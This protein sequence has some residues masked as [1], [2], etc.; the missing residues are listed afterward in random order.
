MLSTGIASSLCQVALRDL[1][2]A[3]NRLKAFVL[4]RRV[5]LPCLEYLDLSDNSI[6]TVGSINSCVA[7][8]VLLLQ[9]NALTDVKPLVEATVG[10]VMLSVLR[11]DGNRIPDIHL[12]ALREFKPSLIISDPGTQTGQLMAST[13]M[14][15][16]GPGE[17]GGAEV[18]DHA[19][20]VA[21]HLADNPDVADTLDAVAD[22]ADAVASLTERVRGV[23]VQVG[24]VAPVGDPSMI[25]MGTPPTFFEDGRVRAAG[26][27]FRHC[28]YIVWSLRALVCT[29]S[30]SSPPPS[31]NKRLSHS[32]SA[33]S[34]STFSPTFVCGGRWKAVSGGRWLSRCRRWPCS[35]APSRQQQRSAMTFAAPSTR[36]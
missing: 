9:G 3:N 21:D 30:L 25:L 18:P 6:F 33:C 8:N 28:N 1:R 11:L 32:S 15:V 36:V 10:C 27:L 24:S 12:R 35:G 16:E 29:K 14:A 20:A 19:E 17:G 13:L 23:C 34:W 2:L 4:D 31:P 22:F 5:W 7:L 26:M